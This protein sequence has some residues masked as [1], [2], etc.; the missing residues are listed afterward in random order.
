MKIQVLIKIFYRNLLSKP[1][2]FFPDNFDSSF[3]RSIKFKDSFLVECRSELIYFYPYNC[4]LRAIIA[5][6]FPVPA[7]P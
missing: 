4:L 6:V 3:I 2:D 5:D 1:F 7:G